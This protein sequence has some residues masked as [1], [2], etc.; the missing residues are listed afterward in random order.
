MNTS[1]NKILS[2]LV[3]IIVPLYNQEFCIQKCLSSLIAQ[4]YDN[5]EIIIVNDGSDD[6]S[7]SLAQKFAHE[8]ARIKLLNQGNAGV[9]SARNRALDA[10]TGQLVLF[11]DADDWL[12]RSCVDEAVEAWIEASRE[13]HLPVALRFGHRRGNEVFVPEER[14]TSARESYVHLLRDYDICASSI[15]GLLIPRSVIEDNT[16][17]FKRE[18]PRSEDVLFLAELYKCG[19]SVSGYGEALYNYRVGDGLGSKT[20]PG[21][22]AKADLFY[23]TL[24]SYPSTGSALDEVADESL[25]H[26][27]ARFYVL[28]MIIEAAETGNRLATVER[29]LASESLQ[30]VMQKARTLKGLPFW[31]RAIAK[32]AARKNARAVSFYLATLQ[33]SLLK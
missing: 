6:S 17:R 20:Y 12:E 2:P 24:K 29:A 25:I 18:L 14:F 22:V 28:S 15:W 13:T 5:L 1:R 7:L 19:C 27:A 4:S 10:A 8:D 32:S 9:S 11:V 26:Y 31:A 3:S 30:E 21:A 33:K 16:L 23:Q